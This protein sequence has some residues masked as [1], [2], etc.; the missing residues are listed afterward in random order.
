MQN[1][2][3][4][5]VAFTFTILMI[6][7]KLD[8]YALWAKRLPTRFFSHR[9]L[10]ENHQICIKKHEF[11]KRLESH[12]SHHSSLIQSKLT[13]LKKNLSMR[14]WELTILSHSF[15]TRPKV[16]DQTKRLRETLNAWYLSISM[17]HS[18]IFMIQVSSKL[19]KHW[20]TLQQR[21]K[22]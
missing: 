22:K 6:L 13:N 5:E 18:W 16:Y 21:Q 10:L 7:I 20:K 15:E 1:V 14:R 8:L 12:L 4:S 11:A 9:I 17:F 19:Q 3:A 2:N